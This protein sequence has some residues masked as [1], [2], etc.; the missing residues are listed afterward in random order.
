MAVTTAQP[1]ARMQGTLLSGILA[2]PTQAIA[3]TGS[4]AF[5]A[6]YTPERDD[7]PLQLVPSTTDPA[8]AALVDLR[9]RLATSKQDLAL[10][11][12]PADA[13]VDYGRQVGDAHYAG[14]SSCARNGM[15]RC[16]TWTSL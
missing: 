10:A 5:R 9:A 11:L 6:P 13:Y 14:Y 16:G 3:I 12:Q 4:P 15:S 2:L 8:V 7:E 1:G